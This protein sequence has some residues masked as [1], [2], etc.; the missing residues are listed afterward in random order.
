MTKS[1][2]EHKSRKKGMTPKQVKTLIEKFELNSPENLRQ[3]KAMFLD[4]SKQYTIWVSGIFAKMYDAIY[5]NW[6]DDHKQSFKKILWYL[7]QNKRVLPVLQTETELVTVLTI[8]EKVDMIK[9]QLLEKNKNTPIQKH[10]INLLNNYDL[11]SKENINKFVNDI[12]YAYNNWQ[13]IRKSIST[14]L[15]RTRNISDHTKNIYKDIIY[16]YITELVEIK[17]ITANDI[18]SCVWDVL[19]DRFIHV[20]D[21]WINKA[22]IQLDLLKN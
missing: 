3:I 16:W 7:L 22:T 21:K 4:Y 2:L 8:G 11:L 17:G 5:G 10:E 19:Q 13:D 20:L 15:S 9:A 14:I 6:A 18:I 12:L 1:R